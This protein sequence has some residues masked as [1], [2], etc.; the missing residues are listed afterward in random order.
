MANQQH[1]DILKHGVEAWSQWRWE[2]PDVRPDFK[3]ADFWGANLTGVNL[4]G[5]D[6]REA[7]L[8]GVD[9]SRARLSR[10]VLLT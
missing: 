1:L 4:T 10:V 6:L 3:E 7:D 5:A 2:H 9:I 8:W